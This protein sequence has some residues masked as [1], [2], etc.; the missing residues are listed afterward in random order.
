MSKKNVVLIM[1][2]GVE[3][4]GVTKFTVEQHNW[5]KKHGYNV[6]SFASIDKNYSRKNVHDTSNFELI[7]FAND[8]STDLMIEACNMA[9][10][11]IVNS[12]P[13]KENHRSLGV[14]QKAYDNWKRALL[15]FTKPVVLVQHDHKIYSIKRNACLE[16][17]ID[18][19]DLIMVHSM[20]NDFVNYVR[21]RK[22]ITGI[23]EEEKKIVSFQP[24]LS[25]DN[26][27]EKYWVDIKEQDSFH[28]KWIGRSTSWKGYDLMF[29]WYDNYLKHAEHVA[30]FEGIDKGP[31]FIDFKAKYNFINKMTTDPDT[32]KLYNGEPAT[33]FGSFKNENMLRRMAKVAFGYQLSLLE[34]KYIQN[35]IEYTHCELVACGALPVF[36]KEY[37][38]KCIHRV[39]GD[40]LS[41]SKGNNT[42]WLSKDNM[43]ECINT[44]TS[45]AIDYKRRD[46]WRHAAYE[47]YK[48]HQDSEHVFKNMMEKIES[49]L[50]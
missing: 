48:N 28:H 15:S 37:G 29:S 13:P 14:E 30:S 25:F 38:D 36:R 22:G 17:A 41:E 1:A 47:F 49:N 23:F 19:A 35:S 11:V 39:T 46:D 21:T 31:A 6:R 43:E 34:P 3:G 42:I 45:L 24:G 4:C 20:E 40:P 33:V 7:K 16:E 10:Y 8:A 2:R 44:V 32:V 5:F 27:K 26:I 50:K 12:L 9:D 18:A